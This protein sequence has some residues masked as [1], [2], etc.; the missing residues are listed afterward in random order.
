MSGLPVTMRLDLS[1]SET[2]HPRDS[3]SD[4]DTSIRRAGFDGA[5]EPLRQDEQGFLDYSVHVPHI[6][7]S[8]VEGGLC[9]RCTGWAVSV[10]HEPIGLKISDSVRVRKWARPVMSRPDVRQHYAA[11]GLEVSEFSG[12]DFLLDLEPD[13]ENASQALEIEFLTDRFSSGQVPL[14]VTGLYRAHRSALGQN[15]PYGGTQDGQ[16]GIRGR[17]DEVVGNRVVG[18]AQNLATLEPVSVVLYLNGERCAEQAADR[19]REDL[20]R[21]GF[22]DSG[23]LAFEFELE[24]ELQPGDLVS[25]RVGDGEELK[26][27]PLQVI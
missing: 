26:N 25:V 19:Y 18:W 17:L 6:W 15:W 7:H 20:M 3:R 9:L 8:D 13:E 4:W 22:S 2:S 12:F 14:D 10:P 1:S 23:E 27:S 5:G 24:R 21:V 16:S 11:R